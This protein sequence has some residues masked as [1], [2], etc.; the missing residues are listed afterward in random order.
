MFLIRC[1]VLLILICK[2]Q[3]S[4][5]MSSEMSPIHYSLRFE[6]ALNHYL[7]VEAIYPT[8]GKSDLELMMATWTPGSYLVREYARH[9]EDLKATTLDGDPLSFEKSRKNRWVIDSSDNEHIRVNYRIYC[10]EMTVRSN[11][12]GYDFAI[13]NGASTFIT[14]IGA[15]D[16]KHIIELQLPNNWEH[17]ITGLP[18]HPE[19]KPHTYQAKNFDILVDSPI[20]VGNPN[21]YEFEVDGKLHLLVNQGEDGVWDGPRSARDIETI[22]RQNLDFWGFLPYERY[23]FLNMIVE[24]GGGLEH[25]NSTL[26]MAN[27]WTSRDPKQ[28]REWLGLVCHE[29][30]HTWNVKRLRPAE[31]GPF[32]Y[33]TET[34][35][36]SLWIAEGLTSYYDDLLLRRAGLL[37]TKQY[38]EA[39]S[40]HIKKVQETPGRRIASLEQSSFDAWIKF[41]RPDENSINSTIS[42]YTKGALVGFLLDAHLRSTSSGKISLDQVM[43]SAMDKYSGD[44]GYT[45][46]EFRETAST[47]VEVDLDSWF[48][49]AV[50]ETG[51]L[52]YTEALELYGLEFE[53]P[54]MN[55]EEETKELPLPA[56]IG[57]TTRNKDG[58]LFVKQ[59]LR[60]SPAYQSG[61]NA[62][63]EILALNGFRVTPESFKERIKQYPPEEKL[64]VLISRRERLLNLHITLGIAPQDTWEL[65]VKKDSSVS[66]KTN[67]DDWLGVI[68]KD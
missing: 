34:H 36:K 56:W 50:Q 16:R 6:S 44:T 25:R 19:N 1:F 4:Y 9:V 30:F 49:R 3:P 52:D 21:V 57:V 60:G 8:D 18:A 10:R 59:V 37:T 64:T 12:V 20:F 39:L 55:P 13:L 17:S 5:L 62:D 68:S 61:V 31:L 11:W 66:Q 27:R 46:E 42:Y 40:V 35:T 48:K 23:V 14:A 45:P 26:M 22:V 7:D 65:K 2:V 32:N 41:Y 43:L 29:F 53:Q 47:L 51:E 24:A 15:L 33:E 54:P 58:R 28:Y 67:L 38:L 63:D